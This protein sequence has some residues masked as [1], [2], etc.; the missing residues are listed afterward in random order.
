MSPPVA[1]LYYPLQAAAIGLTVKQEFAAKEKAKLTKKPPTKGV[2][3]AQ[4]ELAK[5]AKTA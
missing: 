3:K 1:K 5:K 4:P 2:V